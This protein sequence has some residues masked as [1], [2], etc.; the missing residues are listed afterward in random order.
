M[1][2]LYVLEGPYV[3]I[4]NQTYGG[5][6]A[7][8]PPAEASPSD[9]RY[10][11]DE[12]GFEAVNAYYHIDLSQ[13][14]V[15]SLGITDRQNAPISV[16]PRERTA[17]D[18][19][20]LPA[21]NVLIF[22]LGGVDDAEDATV[23]W[24]EYAHALLNAAAP[25]I[26]EFATLEG[27]AYHEGWSDYWATSWVREL[28]ET[29]QLER[30]DWR[31]IFAWDSGDGQIWAGRTMDHYGH[32][33]EDICSDTEPPSTCSHHDDGRLFATALHEV[34]D[35]VDRRT[36]DEIVLR[37]HDYLTGPLT[38]A[39]AADAVI[40]ADIDY[41]GGAH[42]D[43]LI[44]VFDARGLV[45]RSDFGPV[46]DHDA[47]PNMEA[48]GTEV[49][50]EASVIALSSDV[51]SVL[52]HV[53]FDGGSS[54]TIPMSAAGGDSYSAGLMLPETPDSVRYYIE[55]RDD[56]GFSGFLPTGA[57]DRRFTFGVGPDGT[58][59]DITH[60]PVAGGSIL[61][62]PQRLEAS[63][64]DNIGVDRVD[65]TYRIE[66]PGGMLIDEGSFELSA[67]GDL[68]SGAFPTPRDEVS[69]DALVSY[70]IEAVDA[71][72]GANRA[73]APAA[74]AYTFTI[75]AEGLLSEF[76]FDTGGASPETTGSWAVGPP[77]FGVL[78]AW[79]GGGVI[80]TALD[81]PTSESPGV[82]R[83]DLPTLNLSGLTDV[84]LRFRHWF[85]TEH[86]GIADP[87]GSDAVLFDGGNVKVSTDG[88][89]TWQVMNPT[90]GTYTGTLDAS[91]GN[92]LAGEPAFG[93]Y[94]YGWRLAEFDLPGAE[95]VTVRFE[96]GTDSG[97]TRAARAFAGWYLD[98]IRIT[99]NALQDTDPPSTTAEPP[100]SAVASV[101]AIEP[102]VQIELADATGV[103]D[104]LLDYEYQSD[105]GTLRMEMMPGSTTLFETGLGFATA[106][107]PG[108][109]VTYRIRA[110]DPLG[111]AV[112]L[113][114]GGASEYR[115]EY[116]LVDQQDV[117]EGVVSSGAFSSDGA[118][119][120]VPAGA[121]APRLS[122]LNT[123]PVDLP[124]NVDRQFLELAHAYRLVDAT[125]A[126]VKI[127]TDR[128]GHWQVLD[129]DSG[130]DGQ[131]P[132][133]D[134]HPM[135]GE[136]SFSGIAEQVRIERFDLSAFAGQQVLIRFDFGDESDGS[137]GDYW[138]I[139]TS[140]LVSETTEPEF[141]VQSDDALLPVFPNPFIDRAT[142]SVSVAETGRVR[143]DVF[144]LLGRRVAVLN[145]GTLEA[146][147]HSFSLEADGWASGVYVV[148]MLTGGRTFTSTVVVAR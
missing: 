117:L 100:A 130:Y 81:A 101:Q 123:R 15:Q 107:E 5:S 137:T 82:S 71:S 54:E 112:E 75:S 28:V 41:F 56:Q 92:P 141:S 42:A 105:A 136:A 11:R 33:P 86:D 1:S 16:N 83:V 72:T 24:H 96:F 49:T 39:D 44:D 126:N 98:D 119:W 142:V 63:V 61:A 111:N 26:L 47:L 7:F 95:S 30:D 21:Q 52:L 13:R 144:D 20:Y 38:F 87:G 80:G 79:S 43:V 76:R 77:S 121:D 66:E 103:T 114:T 69:K 99:T 148:R 73:R 31:R 4:T 35:V 118:E 93:G 68:Y 12:P 32:Y 133:D 104:V 60:T 89:S 97:N 50:V 14:Y 2:G 45:S 110:S 88:G 120:R 115:L 90:I 29:G 19:F 134:G 36:L 53:R 129:P 22:G 147:A 146:G 65:V 128:G 78:T 18:S 62:W 113:P 48:T 70:S 57:P 85:D 23:L 51:Q 55:A 40:Q 91:S 10:R 59:P 145:D 132:L 74:G 25:E 34:R 37:S 67:S 3:R 122:A 131:A 9:F 106:P 125:A 102:T 143:L 124:D 6:V 46:I 140:R 139:S 27:R 17:D 108:D 84:R 116:R 127:S 138:Q 64:T 109:V 8:Q 58:P 135:A 94:G